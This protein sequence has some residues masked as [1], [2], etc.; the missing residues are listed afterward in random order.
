MPATVVR[1]SYDEELA[2]LA[3]DISI[4]QPYKDIVKPVTAVT[5]FL[6]LQK[7]RLERY[8]GFRDYGYAATVSR[9]AKVMMENRNS[10]T[11]RWKPGLKTQCVP[12]KDYK[13]SSSSPLFRESVNEDDWDTNNVETQSSA[14]LLS[15]LKFEDMQRPPWVR[16]WSAWGKAD[17]TDVTLS[18]DYNSREDTTK[19]H[20]TATTGILSEKIDASQV[21]HRPELSIHKRQRKEMDG[22]ETVMQA[23]GSSSSKKPAKQQLRSTGSLG[24]TDARE[25]SPELKFTKVRRHSLGRMSK[26]KPNF[27]WVSPLEQQNL[28]KDTVKRASPDSF[29][30][31]IWSEAE[32]DI[33][34]HSDKGADTDTDK[35]GRPATR[36]FVLD[37]FDGMPHP[38]WGIDVEQ[39]SWLSIPNPWKLDPE[40]KVLHMLKLLK[41]E[42]WP[43]YNSFLLVRHYKPFLKYGMFPDA[44][45]EVWGNHPVRTDYTRSE[46]EHRAAL[47]TLED[48]PYPFPNAPPRINPHAQRYNTNNCEKHTPQP[49]D[50]KWIY[51]EAAQFSSSVFPALYS[52]DYRQELLDL[53]RQRFED[54]HLPCSVDPTWRNVYSSR[55]RLLDQKKKRAIISYIADEGNAS[56]TSSSSCE[57]VNGDVKRSPCKRLRNTTTSAA[58]CHPQLA[59][60]QFQSTVRIS[61]SEKSRSRSCS[62][63]VG[64]ST[65]GTFT[66]SPPT[67]SAER[68]PKSTS[69]TPTRY[70]GRLYSC[71]QVQEFRRSEKH[72][73]RRCMSY[74]FVYGCG[75]L[76]PAAIHT[77]STPLQWPDSNQAV[78]SFSAGLVDETSRVSSYRKRR[79]VKIVRSRSGLHGKVW[80]GASSTTLQ[81]PF[82]VVKRRCG[83]K[84]IRVVA[85]KKREDLNYE[86]PVASLL[87]TD[88]AKY[89][90]HIADAYQQLTNPRVIDPDLWKQSQIDYREFTRRLKLRS[91][92][93]ARN[94]HRNSGDVGEVHREGQSWMRFHQLRDVLPL[95]AWPLLPPPPVPVPASVCFPSDIPDPECRISL[96]W[97]TFIPTLFRGP[98]RFEDHHEALLHI[99]WRLNNANRDLPPP[100]SSRL[101][102]WIGGFMIPHDEKRYRFGDDAWF[103]SESAMCLGVCDGV[104]EMSDTQWRVAGF[105]CRGFGEDILREGRSEVQRVRFSGRPILGRRL[106]M[107]LPPG[108]SRSDKVWDY[109]PF[110]VDPSSNTPSLLALHALITGFYNKTTTWG[111]ATCL[112]GCTNNTGS[113]L[114]VANIGDSRA[115]ILRRN[116]QSPVSLQIVGSTE[117]EQHGWNLPVQLARLPDRSRVRMMR[118]DSRLTQLIN[119]LDSCRTAG[120][121]INDAAES[122][123]LYDFTIQEGDLILFATDGLWDN[124]FD[125]EVA[126]LCGVALSPRESYWLTD[127]PFAST[128][129]R[130]IAKGLCLAAYWKSMQSSIETPFT[131]S[132]RDTSNAGFYNGGKPDDITVVAAWV[133]PASDDNTQD[134]LLRCQEVS[135]L[136]CQELKDQINF[137]QQQ[138]EQRGLGAVHSTVDVKKPDAVS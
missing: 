68:R 111:A 65:D 133:V 35:E 56:D 15:D 24:H 12:E 43:K 95:H 127:S 112:F 58:S 99:M 108:R 106:R 76:L 53:E 78:R 105:D 13:P 96:P 104:G 80:V 18:H 5:R 135:A 109:T 103:G 63:S 85:P 42:V 64:D 62:T 134:L 6:E 137:A 116:P 19:P 120:Q 70:R 39:S 74:P 37:P 45:F 73:V 44:L 117:P 59:K 1:S 3:E 48:Y 69:P 16:R 33:E 60:Q 131:L 52:T 75:S 25:T 87:A 129:P 11:K 89:F 121:D 40:C 115:L 51:Q 32:T 17:S 132:V 67:A 8:P 61:H 27:K 94:G 10:E 55:A 36:A 30:S 72:P 88:L 54:L 122:A 21:A 29:R 77:A 98:A 84:R 138:L 101:R 50:V 91:R 125:S 93:R 83:S 14:V 47:C 7:A 102:L 9:A 81:L 82:E 119:T 28:W 126:A 31:V 26:P 97:P 110:T 57:P 66:A 71:S 79:N 136:R 128:A 130:D 4:L 23:C 86:G 123:V 20:V 34:V 114:G 118:G 46:L 41:E 92:L 22:I 90:R 107:T 49:V 113:R 100:R 124:L 2:R 38:F